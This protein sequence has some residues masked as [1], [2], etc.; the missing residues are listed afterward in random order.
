MGKV[1]LLCL[2]ILIAL[3][4]AYGAPTIVSYSNNGTD[5]T[6]PAL[7]LN[8]GIL[9]EITADE[10]ITL[11]VWFVDGVDQSN[12]RNNLSYSWST[13]GYKTVTVNATGAS[14]TSATVTMHPYV[15]KEMATSAD[16]VATID[17][18]GY[19]TIIEEVGNVAPD[20]EV[21]LYGS[22]EPYI[23]LFDNMAFLVIFGLPFV[24]MWIRQESMIMP[25]LFGLMFGTLIFAFLPAQFAATASAMIVLSIMGI[26]FTFY[27]ERR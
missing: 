16:E 10:A 6:Y 13:S 22:M 11:Y 12:N 5:N 23:T 3:N 26:I 17:N 2:F 1:T 14:G 8:E 24:M 4:P 19:A 21:V 7:G 18:P 15:R 25:A 9:F 20:F 27:K